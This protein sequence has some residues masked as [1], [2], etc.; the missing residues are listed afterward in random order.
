MSIRED[1]FRIS[2]CGLRI[3]GG[4]SAQS[5]VKNPKSAIRGFTLTEILLVVAI[6]AIVGGLGGGLYANSYKRLLV[7]KTARQLLLM[8]RYARIVAIEQQR[9][10]EL[11]LDPE[12]GFLLTT[13]QRNQE[14]GQ[15]EQTIVKDF[16]CRPVEFEGEVTFE[17]VRIM[18][19][20]AETANGSEPEQKIVFLPN[21][22]TASAV[23]QMGDGTTHYTITLV[24]ATG[25][26]TLTAGIAG[27]I[28]TGTVDLDIQQE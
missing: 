10:Y 18:T 15:T 24:A 23:I 4:H 22:S 9:P 26:A 11:Q 20:T 19:M 16:Y 13:V 1:P 28:K 3:R 8:A 7:E 5:A 17:E 21:G 27:E 6:I 2:N 25:K 12:N 14:T